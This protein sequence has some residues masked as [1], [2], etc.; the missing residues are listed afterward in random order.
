MNCDFALEQYKNFVECA[1]REL[2][3]Q[4]VF[5]LALVTWHFTPQHDDNHIFDRFLGFLQ[6]PNGDPDTLGAIGARFIRDTGKDLN[7]D[8]FL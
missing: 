2:S 3:D 7:L 5:T 1:L 4:A 6:N 8:F